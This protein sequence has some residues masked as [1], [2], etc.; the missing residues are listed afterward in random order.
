MGY[1]VAHKSAAITTPR[2]AS[3]P[4]LYAAILYLSVLAPLLL[5]AWWAAARLET[6]PKTLLR[7]GLLFPLI[8]LPGTAA[9]LLTGS[10]LAEQALLVLSEEAYRFV[11]VLALGAT[12]A[13]RKAAVVGLIFAVVETTNWLFLPK[14]AAEVLPAD[15]PALAVI[16][17]DGLYV[18]TE[19]TA[20]FVLHGALTWLVAWGGAQPSKPQRTV[21]TLA[22]AYGLH[23]GLNLIVRG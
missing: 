14:K 5:G 16:V 10:V 13:R 15:A 1:R 9:G 22:L 23:L 17:G 18:L 12:S 3:A 8:V 6:N 2:E 11:A 4:A 21:S 20:G 19:F 7:L